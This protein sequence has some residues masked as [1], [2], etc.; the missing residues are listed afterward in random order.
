MSALAEK[1]PD[2]FMF[3]DGNKDRCLVMWRSPQEWGS[4]I[5]N[6]VSLFSLSPPNEF[7]HPCGCKSPALLLLP[8][9]MISWFNDDDDDDDDFNRGH[10]VDST[11]QNGTIMTLYE[12]R[13]GDLAAGQEFEG[14]GVESLRQALEAL[15]CQNKAKL[16]EGEAPGANRS[17]RQD[18]PL[19]AFI[20][21]RPVTASNH[22]SRTTSPSISR[23][24]PP[25]ARAHTTTL[26][27]RRPP[28]LSWAH[29]STA[30]P[31]E[32]AMSLVWWPKVHGPKKQKQQQEFPRL[33]FLTLRNGSLLLPK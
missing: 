31:P 24:R 26:L 27:C 23:S 25:P 12:L 15:E 20:G 13:C 29:L 16:F 32:P 5:Y 6:W 11:G 7:A 30:T 19:P 28:P 9:L 10:Q 14:I 33:Y 18:M 2:N 4:I 22:M 3:L 21:S 17:I 1:R 8:R